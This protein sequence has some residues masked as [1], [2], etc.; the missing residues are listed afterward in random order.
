MGVLNLVSSGEILKAQNITACPD[1]M[2]EVQDTA[3]RVQYSD[4]NV[5]CGTYSAE[6]YAYLVS[7]DPLDKDTTWITR[8][9]LMAPAGLYHTYLY[10]AASRPS[11]GIALESYKLK[12]LFCAGGG[13]D[14]G[15]GYDDVYHAAL[16]TGAAQN[17]STF[18]I[19]ELEHG[20]SQ[21]TLV[22]R[23]GTTLAILKTGSWTW[24]SGEWA[25][26]NDPY[27][28]IGE[29][30]GSYHAGSYTIA[31]IH[32][33]K[34]HN[35]TV[36]DLDT[37]NA[38]RLYSS[39]GTVIASAV[40]SAGVATLVCSLVDWHGF[41]GYVK[42]F[43]DDTYTTELARSPESGNSDSICGGDEYQLAGATPTLTSITPNSGKNDVSS[44]AITDLAG[45]NFVTGATVR[46]EKAGETNI[47]A[48]SV[49]A[50]SS[51]RI[52]C[53]LDLEGENAGLW[54]V[55]V[56]N[57]DTLQAFLME[58]FSI[59]A[60]TPAITVVSPNRAYANERVTITGTELGS[61][62][63]STVAIG[64]VNVSEVISWS[65]TEV[66]VRVPEGAVSGNVA[67]YRGD[68]GFAWSNN[69]PITI[70]SDIL[71]RFLESD[72]ETIRLTVNDPGNGYWLADFRVSNPTVRQQYID[73]DRRDGRRP[74]SA[75]R[76]QDL[77]VLTLTM[78]VQGDD[79]ED[80][81]NKVHALLDEIK[82]YGAKI[83]YRPPGW[84]HSLVYTTYPWTGMD[85]AQWWK[86]AI[87]EN[88]RLVDFKLE[89]DCEP[90]AEA[91]GPQRSI[92]PFESLG[93]HGDFEEWT[94][95]V[96]DGWDVDVVSATVSQETT[97]V[98]HGS[99][100][101][102]I[103]FGTGGGSVSLTEQTL[104]T[105]I[106]SAKHYSMAVW[107]RT[108]VGAPHLTVHL[109]CV[110]A[111]PGQPD[112]V[113][114]GSSIILDELDVWWDAL[115][116]EAAS[117]GVVH[118]SS[119]SESCRWSTG[120]TEVL[121]EI[122]ITGAEGDIIYLDG[123]HLTCTEYAVGQHVAGVFA[124]NIPEGQ[125]EGDKPAPMDIY[126]SSVFKPLSKL[127][128]GQRDLYSDEFAGIANALE[129]GDQLTS[130]GRIVGWSPAR[131]QQRYR[132]YSLPAN[133]INDDPGFAEFS[134]SG[135]ST[136]WDHWVETRSAGSYL[137]D[138][139]NAVECYGPLLTL[140]NVDIRLVH[141]SHIA[142]DAAVIHYLGLRARRFAG[143][144]SPK[145]AKLYLQLYCYDATPALLGLLTIWCGLPAIDV[146]FHQYGGYLL[147][148]GAGGLCFP[149][150]T[151]QV[152]PMLRQY[153]KNV[154]GTRQVWDDVCLFE[155]SRIGECTF[156]IESHRGTYIPLA[157]LSVSGSITAYDSMI[158]KGRVAWDDEEAGTSGY[159][160][161]ATGRLGDPDTAFMDP[162]WGPQRFGE[163]TIPSQA[164]PPD[165]SQMD[166][167]MVIE[168]HP[169]IDSTK[170]IYQEFFAICPTG[171][172]FIEIDDI[173]AQHV[174][175][176][177]AADRPVVLVSAN[178][179]MARSKV[180]S[181]SQWKPSPG[182]EA[183]PDGMNIVFRAIHDNDGDEESWCINDV[184][185]RYRP[186]YEIMSEG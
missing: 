105:G 80:L 171:R 124:V 52:T 128:I 149:T 127:V 71:C 180:L 174:I 179:T 154:Y 177:S 33:F 53:D 173:D 120:T 26:T 40:E 146:D 159:E 74:V 32:Q 101:V 48:S 104:I 97:V 131:Y 31:Y 34:S 140:G 61:G 166:Q 41:E 175:I 66:V 106:D 8:V 117:G 86:S 37:G 178:G 115:E 6:Q 137:G 18:Y 95:G 129:L 185:F 54:D 139:A 29:S 96:P 138:M 30:L 150:G 116:L 122:I 121:R 125:V 77:K 88:D 11:A 13:S 75:S 64:G 163:I 59:T 112:S 133:L 81:S 110:D 42:V 132:V 167:K 85:Y 67:V 161:L 119:E 15:Q 151:T 113:V 170:D 3:G 102:K 76:K 99:S 136:N 58:G 181:P 83:E 45:S 148:A 5:I 92:K 56:Q 91:A 165:I 10:N 107:T 62:A 1:F 182:F 20:A 123:C 156:D 72:Y 109:S 108:D 126:V 172:A 183:D 46:L 65:D 22:W 36:A 158:L 55:W 17:G 134:G 135:N 89:L 157:G 60:P 78:H 50:V 27:W 19:A 147:P 184:E 141:S 152:K 35:I 49:V 103:V 145:L 142:V 57:P 73:P 169:L 25:Y 9:K 43:S 118:P 164:T 24:D 28:V 144:A 51:T 39:D 100:A 93:L 12:S 44:L 69:L 160:D 21:D 143:K 94:G 176:N 111:D 4:G 130:G 90:D 79:P 84:E 186:R 98:R 47:D 155:A 70:R 87:Q 16:F 7:S 23:N 14:N 63:G 82:R 2:V 38:A 168:T 114:L 153:G 162:F 68:A